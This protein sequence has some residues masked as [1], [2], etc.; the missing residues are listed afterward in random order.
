VIGIVGAGGI[1]Q[2]FASHVARAG[3]EVIVSN[4]RGPDS[5]AKLVSELGPHAR[6]GTRAQAAQADVVFLS[7][8]WEQVPDA[9]A[10]LPGW[11]GRIVIDATNPILPGFRPAELNGSTSSEVVASL[12]PGARVVK[13]VNTLPVALLASDP[14]QAG[15]QRVLFLS[16]DDAEAKAQVGGILAKTGFA[17]VDLGGLVSGGRLQ[18]FGG[19]LPALNLIKLS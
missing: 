8:R 9:L 13:A 10:G 19:P 2:A 11:G 1:G 3:Y 6:A 7:V 5:L 18:Q 17:T 16:G 4:S 15:G 14:R 12:V